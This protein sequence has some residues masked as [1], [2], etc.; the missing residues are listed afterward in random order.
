M[1]NEKFLA[2]VVL[3][4][5][6]GTDILSVGTRAMESAEQFS[7][8]CNPTTLDSYRSNTYISTPRECIYSVRARKFLQGSSTGQGNEST[9]SAHLKEQDVS[10]GKDFRE[11]K[12]TDRFTSNNGD[13]GNQISRKIPEAEKSPWF[14]ASV[15]GTTQHDIFTPR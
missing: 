4:F 5:T 13:S 3:A 2:C 15:F 7:N 11:K 9:P 12:K 6:F 10:P 1:M 8:G 14:F